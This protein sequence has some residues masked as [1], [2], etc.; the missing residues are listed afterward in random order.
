[1]PL[2]LISVSI[3]CDICAKAEEIIVEYIKLKHKGDVILKS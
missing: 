1:L 2:A 3:L